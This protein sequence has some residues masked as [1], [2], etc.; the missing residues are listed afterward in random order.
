[1]RRSTRVLM[2]DRADQLLLLRLAAP[3]DGLPLWI[4]PGG[5]IEAG[6]DPFEAA[7]RELREELGVRLH[8]D[9]LTGPVWVQEL[10]IAFGAYTGIQNSYLFARI[11]VTPDLAC[12]AAEWANE[13]ITAVESWDTGRMRATAGR[14]LFS[15]RALPDMLDALL[16]GGVPNTPLLVG[17]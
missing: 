4:A 12:T 11:D 8:R 1:M 9:Q 5:G 3:V 14:A 15:P 16:A 17:L 6:E 10:D 2:V 7:V 13:G